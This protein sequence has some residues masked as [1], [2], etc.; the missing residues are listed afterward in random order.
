MRVSLNYDT[1]MN[2]IYYVR[3][4]KVL[5]TPVLCVSLQLGSVTE[6]LL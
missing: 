2:F 3:G 5:H 1:R 6:P 4:S